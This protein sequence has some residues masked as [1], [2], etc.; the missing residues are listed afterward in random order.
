MGPLKGGAF[1]EVQ[2]IFEGVFA[3]FNPS[4]EGAATALYYRGQGIA[5]IHGKVYAE[6]DFLVVKASVTLEAYAQAS[7]TFEAYRPTLFAL[8]VRVRAEAKL[9]I[10]FF[11]DLVLLPAATRRQHHRRQR[12]AHPLGDRLDRRPGRPAGASPAPG[13]R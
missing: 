7:V 1:V 8:Q 2:V 12:V 11:T 9:K 3:W 13:C 4:A 5:A 10:L 6:V